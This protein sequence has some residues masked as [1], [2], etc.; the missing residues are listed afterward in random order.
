M[1]AASVHSDHQDRGP[2][3]Q[4]RCQLR[5]LR[6][7]L[8]KQAQ[9]VLEITRRFLATISPNTAPWALRT[10]ISCLTGITM[11]THSSAPVPPVPRKR[12]NPREE[13]SSNPSPPAPSPSSRRIRTPPA[14]PT[15]CPPKPT[16]SP[17]S[18]RGPGDCKSATTKRPCKN[19][20]DRAACTAPSGSG[21]A[22][23]AN[24]KGG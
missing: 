18:A 9:A 24:S 14:Q 15:S 20:N 6:N 23:A 11:P 5:T 12:P 8:H 17:A 3:R 10:A 4:H 19:G 13:A 22:R 21:S 16:N 2:V 1:R 7:I